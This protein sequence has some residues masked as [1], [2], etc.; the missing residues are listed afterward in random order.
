MEE[1]ECIFCGNDSSEFISENG[2]SGKK[3]KECQLIYIS[4]R[5]S[6]A[7]IID[8]YG[9]DD[10]H[11]SAQTHIESDFFKS[12]YAKHNLNIITSYINKGSM[13]EI[14]A[15]AGYFLYEA[16]KIGFDPY[17]I[18]FNHTQSR[19]IRENL[20][21]PCIETPLDIS[22][23]DYKKF[24][25]IYHCD[26]LSHFYDPIAEMK[27]MNEMLR[28]DGLLVFETGNFA[29]IEPYYLKYIDKFQYP[30]HLFFFSDK[31][32]NELLD[33][34]GFEVVY[35]YKYSLMPQLKLKFA[36]VKL[37]SFIKNDKKM[38]SNIGSDSI[39]TVD[40]KPSRD[41]SL[42]KKYLRYIYQYLTYFLRY[43][44]GATVMK[45][46]RPQTLI[47]VAKKKRQG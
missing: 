35:I 26:V 19:H 5:P 4:P 8:I 38:D 2:Y 9:H 6:L 28:D 12:L 3:C 39:S 47:V 15:G 29:E 18:E 43:R 1:I 21:I 22:I 11:I 40:T 42:I 20:N 10:A 27:T 30:D 41:S 13:L 17:G 24:D 33:S 36:L 23:Y 46:G 14:G 34:A 16:D 45:R 31:S 32:I 37:L 25:I 7:D 44:V